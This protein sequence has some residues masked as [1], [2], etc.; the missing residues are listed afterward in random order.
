MQ[1]Y[2][3]IIPTPSAHSL[4]VCIVDATDRGL[5]HGQSLI[6]ECTQKGSADKRFS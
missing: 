1:M 3:D 2:T 5:I 4:A 6:L